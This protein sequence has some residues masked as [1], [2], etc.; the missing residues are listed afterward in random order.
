MADTEVENI[1]RE[2]GERVR[3]EGT[4]EAA[5]RNGREELAQQLAQ[6]APHRDGGAWPVEHEMTG[7]LGRLKEHEEVAARAWDRLPPLTTRRRGL[8][9]RL[10]LWLKRAMR[11]ATHWYVWEQLN[12]NSAMKDSLS[13]VSG[14]LRRHE[15]ELGQL[16]ARLSSVSLAHE[17]LAPRLSSLESMLAA[18]ESGLAGSQPVTPDDGLREELRAVRAE[19]A[20]LRAAFD[21]S[22]LQL[23][24]EQRADSRQMRDE[25]RVAFKQLALEIDETASSAERARRKVQSELDELKN[26]LEKRA[27]TGI[28]D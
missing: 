10:E 19:V 16:R 28:S 12:F 9:A 8:A 18:L 15:R 25:Q 4:A 14:M 20:Q 1:L 3:A 21:R 22:L 27:S 23:R 5:P 6:P 26:R 13:E 11:R 17:R 7:A 24:D 2:I